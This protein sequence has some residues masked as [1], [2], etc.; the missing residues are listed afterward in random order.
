MEAPAPKESLTAG[1]SPWK[2]SRRQVI[3]AAGMGSI[4]LFL[5]LSGQPT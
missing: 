4:T 1:N 3:A 2:I 5:R